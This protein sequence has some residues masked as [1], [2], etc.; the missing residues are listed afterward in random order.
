MNV[1]Y[2]N[3]Q[4]KS[5][6]LYVCMYLVHHGRD[7][8]VEETLC[9]AV[10]PGSGL[11][12]P[13]DLVG[14]QLAGERERGGTVLEHSWRKFFQFPTVYTVVDVCLMYNRTKRGAVDKTL[15]LGQPSLGQEKRL[16]LLQ[17][18]VTHTL[19]LHSTHN[20]ITHSAKN[21]TAKS[22]DAKSK[23]IY[24]P[25]GFLLSLFSFAQCSCLEEPYTRSILPVSV[26]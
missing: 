1:Y 22:Y 16:F 14:P 6:G 23:R 5:L 17:P 10:S 24:I 21:Y 13:L 15:P 2:R 3:W 9:L 12:Y 8:A 11:S 25:Y 26:P 7:G 20:H 4:E 18:P 19:Q